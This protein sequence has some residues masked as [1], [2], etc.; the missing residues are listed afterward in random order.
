M[1]SSRSQDPDTLIVEEL[2]AEPGCVLG[3]NPKIEFPKQNPATRAIRDQSRLAPARMA[4]KHGRHLLHHLQIE[5]KQRLKAGRCTF[6]TTWRPL[7]R[8]ARCT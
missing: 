1:L 5:A 7:R 4:L 6:N 2:L 8:L 3:L